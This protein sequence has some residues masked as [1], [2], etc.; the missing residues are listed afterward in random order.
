MNLRNISLIALI[1]AFSGCA[2]PRFEESKAPDSAKIRF[3]TN[4]LNSASGVHTVAWKNETCNKENLQYIT[5]LTSS[6]WEHKLLGM[7]LGEDFKEEQKL[8]IRVPA[9]LPIVVSMTAGTSID[10]LPTGTG[11]QVTRNYCIVR[12]TFT[13]RRNGMYE[14]FYDSKRNSCNL[15]VSRLEATTGGEFI[16]VREESVR[17]L[18]EDC[19]NR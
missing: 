16:R 1:I 3:A 4:I 13:P 12:A 5:V 6:F 19:W 2:T 11:L 15:V 10:T 17:Y 9:E 8:E 18:R 7:P 14:M